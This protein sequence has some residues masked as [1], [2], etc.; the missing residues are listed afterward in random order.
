MQPLQQGIRTRDRGTG[1]QLDTSVRHE[2][3]PSRTQ[4]SRRRRLPPS[5]ATNDTEAPRPVYTENSQLEGA[6]AQ[7]DP[8][9]SVTTQPSSSGTWDLNFEDIDPLAVDAAFAEPQFSDPMMA[10]LA[11]ET[12]MMQ[13][14]DLVPWMPRM[15]ARRLFQSRAFPKASH[16]PLVVLLTGILRS[17]PY[18]M[19]RRNSLPP[20]V[21]SFIFSHAENGVGKPQ[22]QALI[23]CVGLVQLF[24]N[25]SDL[26]KSMVWKLIKLE[27]DRILANHSEFDRWELLASLQALLIYCLLRLQEVP[28][29]QDGLETGLITTVNRVF[30]KLVVLAGGIFQIKFADETNVTWLDWVFN[31]SR[32]RTV[33]IFQI[34]GLLID[35]STEASSYA[36]CGQIL[37][38]LPKN[39][40]LWTADGPAAWKAE[41]DDVFAKERPVYGVSD[42]GDL[43]KIVLIFSGDSFSYTRSVGN[44]DEWRAEVG[45]LGTLVMMVAALL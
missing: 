21:H 38:P 35:L 40:T 19:L 8:I 36:N 2:K 33:L 28:A 43:T 37:I 25:R 4:P 15:P 42:S 14:P 31:E 18:M 11:D 7:W 26:N 22:Q 13:D 16:K 44:W 41:C 29:G 6:L 9:D 17:Y 24:K 20:F 10:T 3:T 5:H 39:S 45:D 12:Y 32:R 23:T 1:C 34:L 27:Q 30:D